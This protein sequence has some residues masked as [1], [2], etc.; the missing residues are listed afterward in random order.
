MKTAKGKIYLFS[1]P[2]GNLGDITLRA[3][4]HLKETSVIFCEDT[5]NT[6]KL[7]QLLDIPFENKRF[8]SFHDH[9]PPAELKKLL[10][11]CLD[12]QDVTLISDAGNPILCDPAFPLIRI[13][14]EN[15]IILDS[16]P[17]VSSLMVALELSGLPPQP[18]A[19]HGFFP[20]EKKD[21]KLILETLESSL[22]THYFFESPQR[23]ITTLTYLASHFPD[24]DFSVMRELTK[25]FQH[26]VRF[27]GSA[28]SQIVKDIPP[29]GEFVFGIYLGSI[30]SK[31]K[32]SPL[33]ILNQA[34]EVLK[35][36]GR[37]KDLAKLLALILNQDTKAIYSQIL[38]K[39]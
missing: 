4:E 29:K 31:I 18:F 3:L 22:G 28:F 13:A 21:Q 34:K 37:P 9:T 8:L 35:S 5:R 17:G 33:P 2:I 24:N 38:K 11:F 23:I 12:G 15:D 20:R 27:K 6:K 36:Q 32:T 25:K 16:I 14:L 10:Q 30:H 19:F 39:D 7:L 26:T 1:T